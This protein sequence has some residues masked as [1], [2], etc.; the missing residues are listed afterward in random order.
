MAKKVLWFSRHELSSEQLSDLERIYGP[1]LEIKQINRTISSATELRDDIASV[2][3]VA[4]VAPLPLQAEFLKL[5]GDDKPVIFCKNNRILV[6]GEKAVFKHAGWFRIKEIKT[7]FK[8][9]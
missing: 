2:D 3:V 4:V 6:Q 1:D 9:L 8:R 7:V 5:A